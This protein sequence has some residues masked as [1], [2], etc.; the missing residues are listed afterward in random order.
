MNGYTAS[1]RSVVVGALITIAGVGLG[2]TRALAQD[3]ETVIEVAGAVAEP[4]SFTREELGEFPQ[5]EA[6][7]TWEGYH[8]GAETTFIG[9]LVW[10]VLAACKPDISIATG[11]DVPLLYV[12]TEAYD[13]YK[14]VVSWGE[15]DP[16]VGD[17]GAI[18]ALTENGAPLDPKLQPAWMVIP[19]DK[20]ISR[21][22]FGVVKLT[23]HAADGLDV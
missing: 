11:D 5:Q 1:R 17:N 4:K 20:V 23:V 7:V 21:S 8:D 13:G 6:K 9:P 12:L 10:D 19:R 2:V 15:L 22:I 16:E 14:S 3:A 18:L